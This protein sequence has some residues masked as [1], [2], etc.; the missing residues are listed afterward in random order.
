MRKAHE[1]ILRTKKKFIAFTLAG[2]FVVACVSAL[3]LHYHHQVITQQT[4]IQNLYS[5]INSQLSLINKIS[6][7]SE[8][9]EDRR[10]SDTEYDQLTVEFNQHIIDLHRTN[11]AL[12]EWLANN[13]FVQFNEILALLKNEKISE[14]LQEYIDRA[15]A[16]ADKEPDTTRE[17][18]RDVRYLSFNSRAGLRSV[19]DFVNEKILAKQNESL[20]LLERMGMLLVSLC[21]LQVILVW[22]LVFRPLYSTI[23]IQHERLSEALLDARSANRSKTDFLANI[24]HEIRT[25]MTAILGYAEILRRESLPPKEVEKS[26]EIIEYNAHHLL[27]LV[28]EILDV[29]KMEA[30]KFDVERE[31][32]DLLRLLNEV[33]SLINV[34]A[35]DKGIELLFKNEGKIPQEVWVDKKR[36]KQILF[37]IVGN[38]IKFTDK[39]HVELTVSFDGRLLTFIVKDTGCGIPE[40]Q[41]GKLFR[42]FEQADTSNARAYSGS[43][44]GLVL[45]RGLAQKMGGDIQ[46][47]SSHVDVGTV[48]EITLDAGAASDTK[49]IPKFSSNISNVDETPEPQHS[50][51]DVRILVVDDAKENARLFKIYLEGAGAIVD[52]V[53]DGIQAIESVLAKPFDVVLLDLQ[54]PGKDGYQVVAELREKGYGL[55]IIALTA[56]AMN[57]EKIKTKNAG[58]D[59]HITKPVKSHVLIDT[60]AEHLQGKN[61]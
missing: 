36:L 28:D 10:M 56:H 50:L 29:S 37:N 42:P 23:L 9:F 48:M 52:T 33:Y 54:M 46:I 6:N 1:L 18:R 35:Q 22:L 24:S 43:G 21:V 40:H 5:L 14:K 15:R 57:E 30:G 55:P 34:K 2:G 60:V 45:S 47:I 38:S 49:L 12:E 32:V 53:H 11:F 39:G 16:L 26:V 27:A 41:I 51:A 44:L 4:A 19:F 59:G 7:L 8:N 17:I 25:P 3:A 20:N 31:S 13:D 58:F 61:A